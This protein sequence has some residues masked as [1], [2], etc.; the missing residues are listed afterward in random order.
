MLQKS[1]M[2]E[3]LLTKHLYPSCTYFKNRLVTILRNQACVNNYARV[4]SILSDP[5]TTKASLVEDTSFSIF[6]CGGKLAEGKLYWAV[7]YVNFYFDAV[8]QIK[9]LFPTLCTVVGR[10][11]QFDSQTVRSEWSSAAID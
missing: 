6:L 5:H 11:V 8:C 3:S 4:K 1:H 9:G 7:S 2:T 10:E